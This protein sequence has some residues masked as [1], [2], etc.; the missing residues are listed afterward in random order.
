MATQAAQLRALANT[1]DKGDF[2][3]LPRKRTSHI[4]IGKVTGPYEHRD[5]DGIARHVRPVEWL[6]EDI[7]RTAFKQDILYMFGAFMAVARIQRNNAERRVAVAAE[8][9]AD[10]GPSGPHR[11]ATDG[12][13]EETAPLDLTAAA[14]D[15]IVAHIQA[16]FKGHG[17]ARLVSGVLSAAGWVT[18]VSPPGA[19]GGRDILAGQGLLGLDEPSL[20]VQVKSQDRPAGVEVYQALVGAMQTVGAKQGLLVCWGG[21]TNPTINEAKGGH[22]TTRFWD[23]ADLVKAI[24]DTYERLPEDIKAELPLQRVWMFVPDASG[25]S[26]TLEE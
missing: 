25:E 11:P 15:E 19:D 16:R 24:Y 6:Q 23:S 17:M 14:H 7:P 26:T 18:K 21:F 5:I 1:I 9:R 20:C 8:T 10:P 3:V 22:F 13:S 2:V 4:A 12:P